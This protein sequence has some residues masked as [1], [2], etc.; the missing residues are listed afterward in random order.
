[1]RP[2]AVAWLCVASVVTEASTANP[3]HTTTAVVSAPAVGQHGLEVSSENTGID[4]ENTGRQC[5]DGG[6]KGGDRCDHGEQVSDDQ[7]AW[8]SVGDAVDLGELADR[9]G[10]EST[11]PSSQQSRLRRQKALVTSVKTDESMPLK[12]RFQHLQLHMPELFEHVSLNGFKRLMTQVTGK[13]ASAT[14]GVAA[15]EPRVDHTKGLSTETQVETSTASAEKSASEQAVDQGKKKESSTSA[16][17]PSESDR[18][19]PEHPSVWE[20]GQSVTGLADV[21]TVSTMNGLL[22]REISE[23]MKEESDRLGRERAAVLQAAMGRLWKGYSDHA[24]GDDEVKPLGKRG[25]NNWGGMGVT[26]VD[27]LDTLWLMGLTEEFYSGRDWVRD[28]MTFDNAG[29]VSVFETTIRVLGGLLSAFE[30]SREKVF[31]NRA[32]ELADKLLPAF[33]SSTGIPY[34]SASRVTKLEFRYLSR[35]L[36]DSTY[37]DKVTVGALGDSFYEYLL[38]VWIQG[39]RKEDKYRQMYDDAMDGVD[40]LLVQKTLSLSTHQTRG[41]TYLSEW[42][43]SARQPQHRMDHLACFMAGNLALGSIT[44]QDPALAYTCHQMYM[45][46]ATG[47]SPETVDFTGP[48]GMRARAKARFYILRPETLESFF[49]LHQLTGDPV[50]REWGW[51]IFR[52]IELYCRIGVGYGSHPDVENPTQEPRDHME[53]F[54]PGET[55]KYLYLLMQPDHRIDLMKYTFNTEAHPL[56]VFPFDGSRDSQILS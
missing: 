14:N 21:D 17:P 53:S 5:F 38:K 50:Y 10:L 16:P 56:K 33:A 34:K 23:E 6:D 54:F 47:L 52:A 40:E 19:L 26:L 48:R 18:L 29:M 8:T 36:G 55:L 42:N 2:I 1:M 49:V 35:E 39:G 51:N 28:H 11:G 43:G 32:K 13:G 24:W 30:L 20:V 31:L 44:S 27:S 9:T 46:T 3:A 15:A 12:D 45:M 25:T 22:H 37:A 41:L 7:L 4:S